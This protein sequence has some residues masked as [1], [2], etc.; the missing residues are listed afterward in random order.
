MGAGEF[1]IY[2]TQAQGRDAARRPVPLYTLEPT[3]PMS[4]VLSQSLVSGATEGEL[5]FLLGRLLKLA[6]G[7][8]VLPLRLPAEDLGVL[9]GGLV[10]L[11]VKDYVPIGIAERRIIGEAQRLQKLFPRRLE[12]QL[13]PFAMECSSA[14]LD[15]EALP[16]QIATS[17][18]HAGLL[19]AGSVV[20]A[21]T[22]LARLGPGSEGQLHELLRFAISEECAELR[23]MVGTSLG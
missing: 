23:R 11:F 4:L 2:V 16:A 14:A 19:I 8:L 15:L 20:P 5:R 17:A 6:A 1:D 13:L 9:V 3:E 22:A 10:R 12:A 18:N 7:H 21:Y